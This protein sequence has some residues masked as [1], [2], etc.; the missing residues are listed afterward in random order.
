MHCQGLTFVRLSKNY[1]LNQAL[2]RASDPTIVFIETF[3]N[4]SKFHCQCLILFLCASQLL[5]SSCTICTSSC[6]QW[7]SDTDITKNNALSYEKI[8]QASLFQKTN[9]VRMCKT[10]CN[11]SRR[12]RIRTIKVRPTCFV[13][14]AVVI[15][16]TK[17][18][19]NFVVKSWW[20]MVAQKL[21]LSN[22]AWQCARQQT[23]HL[24][25][26][27]QVIW[28]DSVQWTG[29][30]SGILH[31]EKSRLFLKGKNPEIDR[32]L[33]GPV[34]VWLAPTGRAVGYWGPQLNFSI[35]LF[36][37]AAC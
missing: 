35:S 36:S 1:E 10:S 30:L 26:Q 27:F 15:K 17:R 6:F 29:Q 31:T 22:N 28:F 37:S 21:V 9:H 23:Y 16:V 18:G 32:P 3:S 11:A 7:T 14:V 2:K 5:S 13:T 20:R 8:K 34:N 33:R 4:K 24:Y 25:K 19:H 12:K